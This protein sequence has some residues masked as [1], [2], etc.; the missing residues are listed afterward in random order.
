MNNEHKDYY[1]AVPLAMEYTYPLDD[2]VTEAS[3]Y[4]QLM[5]LLRYAGEGDIVRLEISNY[6]G[7]L[8]TCIAIVNAIRQSAATTVGA[9]QSVAYSAAGAIWLACDVQEVGQ[10]S[11]FMGHPANGGD[12]GTLHQRKTAAEHTYQILESLYRDVYA[13]FLTEEE[14]DSV[15][16][17]DEVWLT[18]TQIKERLEKREADYVKATEEAEAVADQMFE[19]MFAPPPE[20]LLK[21]MTKADLIRMING[22]IGIDDDGNIVELEEDDE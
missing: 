6:G 3:D 16:K 14:I 13:G 9:L 11:S 18:E 10:H 7:S 19:D 1:H 20:H 8:S 17:N 5:H 4:R 12:Y 2:E 22:E 15:L 21:K